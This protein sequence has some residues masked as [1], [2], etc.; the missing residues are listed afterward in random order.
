M[1]PKLR[2]KENLTIILLQELDLG[3]TSS[4]SYSNA[5]ST[6][7]KHRYYFDHIADRAAKPTLM[8]QMID[9]TLSSRSSWVTKGLSCL[10]RHI[11]F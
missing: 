11:H 6:V 10:S 9:P 7:S 2:I 1:L 4:S 8:A 5:S 3:D